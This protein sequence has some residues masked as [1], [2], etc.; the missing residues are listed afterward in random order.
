MNN[1]TF[2]QS[3]TVIPMGH[4]TIPSGATSM[5]D[6]LAATDILGLPDDGNQN[7]PVGP[8]AENCNSCS[9]FHLITSTCCGFGDSIGNPV[10]VPVNTP[11]PTR[12][13]DNSELELCLFKLDLGALHIYEVGAGNKWEGK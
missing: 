13:L 11:T 7:T 12:R 8:G 1:Y 10:L 3:A 5:V 9:F 2:P 4:I 6:S